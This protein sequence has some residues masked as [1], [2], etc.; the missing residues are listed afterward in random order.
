MY[1]RAT[2][3]L[4]LLLGGSGCAKMA[5]GSSAP[6]MEYAAYDDYDDYGG[7]DEAE[8]D[9][10]SAPAMMREESIVSERRSSRRARRADKKSGDF[11]SGGAAPGD[12][13]APEPEPV[14]ATGEGTSKPEP[15]VAEDEDVP[16]HG[17]HIIYTASLQV[18]V[19]NLE[20]AMTRAESL[21]GKYGG[22][23]Q[24]MTSNYFVMR[25]PA[26]KLRQAMDEMAG[27]GTVQNRT[28]DAQD[29]TE[30][31]LDIETRIEV[32]Q[33]TQKQMMELLT[34]A[35]TVEE[36]L[37]VRQALDQITMEL[38]VLK[39]RMRRLSS[40]ISFSTL[41][42][43]LVERGPHNATPSSNDPFPWVDRLGV[44]ATEWK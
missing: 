10:E 25:I 32:L 6:S 36:A 33:A 15:A 30:E 23:V 37:K 26:A 5:S 29:V 40:L 43:N 16:D 11:A 20:D 22:Y 44:E 39:G 35:R 21:P 41:T 28:L 2:V 4:G 13:A 34:K 1:V 31:F 17:R 14:S 7:Y 18:A 27:L 8:A 12:A 3:V 24:N 42:L 38:E 19:F 9:Y